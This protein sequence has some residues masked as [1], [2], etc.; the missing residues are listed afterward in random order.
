MRSCQI[1]KK[2]INLDLFEIN[3]LCLEIYV[4][5]HVLTYVLVY[6]WLGRCIGGLMGKTMSDH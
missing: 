6:G 4:F 1:S 2:L 3:Q 5:W